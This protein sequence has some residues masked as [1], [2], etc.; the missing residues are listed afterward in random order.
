[1]SS[2]SIASGRTAPGG[3]ERVEIGRVWRVGLAAIVLAAVANGIVWVIARAL[4]EIP[5]AF[6]PLASPWPAV[7]FTALYLVIGL[8]VFALL[9]RFTAKPITWFVRIAVVGLL[10]S[11]LNPLFARG[12]DGATTGGILTLEAMHVVAFA[13]F[14][15]LLTTRTR[16]N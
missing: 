12:Q 16:A 13:I 3:G 10:L 11:F 14:V 1:M 5:D 2:S 4:L 8:G 15:P 9:V 7:G 6:L